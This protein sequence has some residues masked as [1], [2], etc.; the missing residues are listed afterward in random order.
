[1][2]SPASLLLLSVRAMSHGGQ[3]P[4]KAGDGIPIP[5]PNNRRR[6]IRGGG[7]DAAH[8]FL[9]RPRTLLVYFCGFVLKRCVGQCFSLFGLL[10]WGV[11]GVPVCLCIIIFIII[12]VILSLQARGL[13][14]AR[15]GNKGNDLQGLTRGVVCV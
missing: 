2:Q 15:N 11:P 6:L 8:Q 3:C 14:F 12:I 13:S 10:G 5:N 9:K 4:E 7:C 1:M